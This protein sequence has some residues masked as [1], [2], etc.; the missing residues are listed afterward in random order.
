MIIESTS[1]QGT[2]HTQYDVKNQD[3]VLTFQTAGYT[4]V[5]ACDGVSLTS[6]WTFSHSE[7]AA[8]IVSK[9]AVSYLENQLNEPEADQP[10]CDT[11]RDAF[12]FSLAVLKEA[13][14][15]MEI[16]FFDCQTTLIVAL[17]KEG[18][19][20][21]GIAGD[22]GILF[23]TENHNVGTLITRL[24]SSSSVYPIGDT[25][26]WRFFEGGSDADP[27]KQ[28]LVA[29]D[30]VFDQLIIPYEGQLGGNYELIEKFFT[31]SQVSASKRNEW[32][33][34]LVDSLPGHD[35]KTIAIVIDQDLKSGE[36]SNSQ[37]K[38][39]A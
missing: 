2:M 24:K 13:L 29:T 5:V 25:Q 6:N 12:L 34:E 18:H 20:W 31:I 35:D 28:F 23:Q 7:I 17:Y 11:I 39:E 26:E 3:A 9:A 19:L 4:G 33:H 32:L 22:G 16:P 1:I 36:K 27:I 37:A 21:A 15:K 10:V 14:D 30:G 38:D 8:A